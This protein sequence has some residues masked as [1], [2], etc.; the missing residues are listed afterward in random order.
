MARFLLIH[1]ACHGA[2]CW[3]DLLP[4]LN[5]G[6]HVARAIDLPAHGDDRTPIRDVTLDLYV[7]AIIAAIDAPVI[8]VGHSLAGITIS[9]V[10]ERVPDKITRLVYLAAWLPG[11]GQSAKD[12]RARAR[13]Q[14]LLDT[15]ITAPDRL[16]TT[17]DP[18]KL[19]AK[20]YHDCPDETVEFAKQNLCP[21]PTAPSNMPVNLGANY[22]C[23]PRSYIRCM[24]DRAIP[25]EYQVTMSQSLPARDVHEMACAHSPFFAQPDKLAEILLKIAEDQ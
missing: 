20:F 23:A 14:P 18:A 8:L 21:E 10:A 5:S 4:L 2:W 16:S 6:D 7:D 19:R 17:L 12:V 22:A 15:L 11:D 9:A 13:Q 25:P 24:D 1:G 3:R